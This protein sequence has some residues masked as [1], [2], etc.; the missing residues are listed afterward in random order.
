[1][2]S[3]S[4]TFCLV[5][6]LSAPWE[7]YHRKPFIQYIAKAILPLNGVVVC[8]EPTLTS[9]H[10]L[11]K[12]PDRIKK[13]IRG[14]YKFRKVN[15]NIYVFSPKTLEHLFLSVRFSPLRRINSY[16]IQKQLRKVL[17]L[18]NLDTK[19]CVLVIHRPELYFLKED[20]E[21]KG[22]VY[23]CWDDFCST[24]NMKS[25]K[26]RGNIKREVLTA[27]NSSF[28]VATSELLFKR[29]YFNNSNTYLI[30][31][32]FSKKLFNKNPKIENSIEGD[33]ADKKNFKK[34]IIGYIGNIKSW[35]D[36]SLIEF[37]VTSR[38]EWTFLFVGPLWAEYGRSYKEFL[39]NNK[40]VLVSGY[41]DYSDFP[42]YLRLFDVGIIPF[43]QNEF[44]KAVNPNKFYEYLGAGIPIVST[45]V[46]DL[47]MKYSSIV[48]VAQT[49]EEFLMKLDELIEM[50]ILDKSKLRAKILDCSKNHTLESNTQYFTELLRKHIIYDN[51]GDFQ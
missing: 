25:L 38:K 24:S 45:D 1:M 27:Q 16:L 29:N 44:M 40:N 41:V 17:K 18:F 12:Y 46:G 22:M 37:L 10:T 26:V 35:I 14:Q 6:T 13:W 39:D 49:K 8:L 9:L 48:R 47:K 34:P 11:L 15:E 19:N 30:E 23:D 36:F 5:Y 3:D 20:I 42:S 33:F 51:F 28:I 31:N 50:D 21:F 43:Y 2:N 32:G 4:S 7:G